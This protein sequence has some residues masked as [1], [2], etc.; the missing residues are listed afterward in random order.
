MLEQRYTKIPPTLGKSSQNS[1][2]FQDVLGREH[3]LEYQWFQHWEIF[4]AMLKCVFKDTPGQEYVELEKYSIFDSQTGGRPIDQGMWK[5][6][7]RLKSHIKMSII[8][9]K[10]NL[11][12]AQ[13]PKCH[14]PCGTQI[15]STSTFARW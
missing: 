15:C 2:I 14:E 11:N 1:F 10:Q 13:C 4:A 6:V 5:R 8:I 9:S 3:V 12:S 7:I